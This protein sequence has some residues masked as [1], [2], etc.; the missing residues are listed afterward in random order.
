MCVCVLS[1]YYYVDRTLLWIVLECFGVSASTLSVIRQFH[2]GMRACF[3]DDGLLCSEWLS[4]EESLR[5]RYVLAPWLFNIFFTA[6]LNVAP[7]VPLD[8]NI[9]EDILNI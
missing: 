7:A 4:A 5:Q 8:T 1:M 6:A 2:G 3:T 9:V